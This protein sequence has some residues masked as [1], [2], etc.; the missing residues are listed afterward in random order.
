MDALLCNPI[1]IGVLYHYEIGYI[2]FS[3]SHIASLKDLV[4]R[5]RLIEYTFRPLGEKCISIKSHKIY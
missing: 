5:N 1:I 3:L 4:I 2:F